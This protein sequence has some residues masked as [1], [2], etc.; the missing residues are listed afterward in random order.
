MT[1]Q[2]IAGVF[3]DVAIAGG[4]ALVVILVQPRGPIGRRL[5]SKWHQVTVARRVKREWPA[6]AK[7]LR[8]DTGSNP[9][10]IVEFADYQCPACRAENPAMMQVLS[11]HPGIGIVFHDFPITSLHPRAEAAAAAS[12]C[13]A[14]QG[15]F[16]AMH[17]ELFG[18]SQWM[19]DGDWTREAKA[20]GVPNVA[21][22]SACL[23][24]STVTRDIAAEKR[25]GEEIGVQAT[26]TFVFADGSVV[27]GG[28]P[29]DEMVDRTQHR[30]GPERL[31]R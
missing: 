17:D 14:R 1:R 3:G 29:A 28:M 18:T 12:L 27:P 31:P 7:G 5:I 23:K 9:V 11:R 22:F 13:A 21:M 30:M 8:L 15:R 26:P 4:L 6:L 24:D 20:V 16:R 19:Q 25:L 2:A 10:R